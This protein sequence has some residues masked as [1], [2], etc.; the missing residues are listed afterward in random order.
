MHLANL[1]VFTFILTVSSFDCLSIQQ[2]IGSTIVVA[3]NELWVNI[4]DKVRVGDFDIS[5]GGPHP[6]LSISIST[7]LLL[8]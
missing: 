2:P 5:W 3:W 6:F 4:E 1:H 7:E 8:A